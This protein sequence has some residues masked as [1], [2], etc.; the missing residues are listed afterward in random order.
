MIRGTWLTPVL[1]AA[2]WDTMTRQHTAEA[3]SMAKALVKFGWMK[4]VVVGQSL[5]LV[6]APLMAWEWRIVHMLKT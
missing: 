5:V 4:F 6:P 1:C 3:L 2:S